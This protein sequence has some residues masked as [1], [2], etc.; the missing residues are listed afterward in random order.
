MYYVHE[1]PTTKLTL[2]V[3]FRYSGTI[4]NIPQRLYYIV[5]LWPGAFFPRL[6]ETL[7]T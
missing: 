3:C 5:L 7:R 2:L 1:Q 4:F 6:A